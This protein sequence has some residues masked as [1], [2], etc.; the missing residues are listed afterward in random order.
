MALKL[1]CED[2]DSL[3]DRLSASKL[4][5]WLR[6]GEIEPYGGKIDQFQVAGLRAQVAN[7]LSKKGDKPFESSDFIVGYRPKMQIKPM[8]VEELYKRFT[9]R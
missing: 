3:L 1:G 8:S 7:Y 9:R 4:L 6:F 2:A 5:E